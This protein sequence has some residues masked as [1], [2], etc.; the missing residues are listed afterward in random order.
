[1]LTKKPDRL[2]ETMLSLG[3]QEPP[4]SGGGEGGGKV[5]TGWQTYLLTS[6]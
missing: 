4:G 2:W 5:F 3:T 1:M 6:H